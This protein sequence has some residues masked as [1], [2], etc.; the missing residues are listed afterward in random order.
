MKHFSKTLLIVITSFFSDAFAMED[1]LTIVTDT[2]PPYVIF[3]NDQVSGTDVDITKAVF[4]GMNIPVRIEV[5]P[6]KR[7]VA[8]VKQ[9]KTDGI[10]GISL[11]EQ[12]KQFLNYPDS[13]ISSGIT[14]FFTKKDAQL[15]Y[16]DLSQLNSPKAGAILGYHYC[17]ALDNTPLLK[18]AERVSTLAQNF[19]KLL[20]DRLDLVVEVDSVGL[21]TAKQMGISD[22]VSILPGARF[23]EGGNYLAFSKKQGYGKLAEQFNSALNAF[24]LTDEYLLILQK[25]GVNVNAKVTAESSA[26]K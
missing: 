9:Q 23:C 7:S 4:K 3:E 6:W 17:D 16:S 12:R 10:L 13:P 1:T 21:Y 11:N 25:Y 22:Q 8:L 15:T 20:R 18:Q 26:G 24:K 5:L 19:N 2:W 14:V